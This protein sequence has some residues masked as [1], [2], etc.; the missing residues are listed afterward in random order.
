M[1][2]TLAFTLQFLSVVLF[3]SLVA[4]WY[5]APDFK[6]RSLRQLLLPLVSF[7]ILRTIGLIYLTSSALGINST[8]PRDFLHATAY[9][10]LIAA[11][12]AALAAL[13]LLWKH[14][15]AYVLVWIFN[16]VGFVDLV[17]AMGNG[18]RIQFLN[19]VVGVA[20]FLP[21]FIVPALL[22]S[23]V[24]IFYLLIKH[25]DAKTKND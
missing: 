17:Y 21:A 10:D 15:G 13:L 18:V 24:V 4:K 5:L 19:H 7:H 16:I 3:S 14:R 2:P 8:L 23:H 9:G 11:I 12:L 6:L 25:P 20:W 1:N 22:V